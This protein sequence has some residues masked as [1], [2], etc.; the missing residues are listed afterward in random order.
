MT[1]KM[2]H[3]CSAVQNCNIREGCYL[4]ALICFWSLLSLSLLYD[5]SSSRCQLFSPCSDHTQKAK[6]IS[7]IWGKF[8]V[9]RTWPSSNLFSLYED[10]GYLGGEGV[11]TIKSLCTWYI[12][13]CSGGGEG[14]AFEFWNTHLVPG[15]WK[16][17]RIKER[18]GRVG[19]GYLNIFRIEAPPTKN[20]RFWA[21]SKSSK[22]NIVTRYLIIW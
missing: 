3:C 17:S 10:D 12:P 1:C 16:K 5:W 15:I 18:S 13:M 9:R 21:I 7:A 22:V 8:I 20:W 6:R 19:S 4:I 11:M 2:Y 14:Q